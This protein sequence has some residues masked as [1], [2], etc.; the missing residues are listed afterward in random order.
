MEKIIET[1]IGIILVLGLIAYA[2]LGQVSGVKDTG[3]KAQVEQ[4]KINQ[5]LSSSDIVTGATVRNYIDIAS[6]D[7]F[8]TTDITGILGASETPDINDKKL[9]VRVINR[10]SDGKTE[11]VT[12]NSDSKTVIKAKIK[13]NAL[14]ETSK[15]YHPDGNLWIIEFTQE[16]LSSGK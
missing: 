12:N 3:D 4:A 9:H 1:V 11:C 14:Y 16:N 6:E 10:K 8:G 5:M 13:E 2:I 15:K 7:K